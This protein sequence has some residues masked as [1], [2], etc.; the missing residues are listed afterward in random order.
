M[1]M[2]PEPWSVQSR[3]TL[4]GYFHPSNI[5]KEGSYYYSFCDSRQL[6]GGTNLLEC[7]F[8][9]IRTSD[10]ETAFGWEYWNGSGWSPTPFG[11]YH[12]GQGPTQPY[13]FFK[14]T[15]N[16]PYTTDPGPISMAQS[17][18]YHVP[19]GKWMLFGSN[20]N[21]VSCFCYCVSDTLANPQFETNGVKEV[22]LSGGG[23]AGDYHTYSGHYVSV[24]DPSST[25]VNYQNIMGN[26]AI[27]IVADAAVRYRKQTISIV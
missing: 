13:V 1:V 8:V 22:V 16:D 2:V 21:L 25:D 23:A 5:V 17:I 19:S 26:T 15:G 10:L 6:R 20:G 18:R 4:Y 9:M 27:V 24:F 7:G 3:D 12:G 11:G 14:V